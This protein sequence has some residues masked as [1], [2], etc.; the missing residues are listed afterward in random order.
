MRIESIRSV[1]RYEIQRFLGF[2]DVGH[3]LD[4]KVQFI[5]SSKFYAPT[6]SFPLSITNIVVLK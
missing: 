2:L 4:K 6:N 3:G 5:A 1:S